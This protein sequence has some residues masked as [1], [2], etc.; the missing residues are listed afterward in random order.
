M[1]R[2]YLCSFFS[3]LY[4]CIVIIEPIGLPESGLKGGSITLVLF[5]NAGIVLE[6]L[7]DFR[8]KPI[9]LEI[10]FRQVS[11]QANQVDENCLVIQSARNAFC[12]YEILYKG[13]YVLVQQFVA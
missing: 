7:K 4:R 6:I 10:F 3:F 8:A 1:N 12:R 13:G 5:V 9:S 2:H 11:L